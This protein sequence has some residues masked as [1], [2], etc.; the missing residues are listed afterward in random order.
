M[1]A[2][3]ALRTLTSINTAISSNTQN[4]LP[5]SAIFHRL[6]SSQPQHDDPLPTNPEEFAASDQDAVFDSSDFAD[7]NLSNSNS[8]NGSTDGGTR[9]IG[10]EEEEK[11]KKVGERAKAL[12]DAALD[13][14]VNEE[15]ED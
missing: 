8:G 12:L 11:K 7:L 2:V 13:D 3:R 14:D 5:K 10:T 6:Y 1:K 4:L 15:A 9:G